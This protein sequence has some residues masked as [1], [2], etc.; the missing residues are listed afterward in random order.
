MYKVS[1]KLMY[2]EEKCK[3]DAFN[4]YKYYQYMQKNEAALAIFNINNYCF[5]VVT[6]THFFEEP[7]DS[8]V[9]ESEMV[10]YEQPITLPPYT[11]IGYC[12]TY[13]KCKAIY[14]WPWYLLA[15]LQSGVI[16]DYAATLGAEPVVN[17]PLSLYKELIDTDAK[18]VYLDK[19]TQRPIF[20]N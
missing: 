13:S 12:K 18:A 4:R 9:P 16:Y 14:H 17:P 8:S 20:I 19:Q 5:G 2:I 7:Y 15:N 1:P 6:Q 3:V 10:C 11:H